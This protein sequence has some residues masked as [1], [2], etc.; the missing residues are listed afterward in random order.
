MKNKSRSKQKKE[1]KEV[2]EES[3][4]VHRIF[5]DGTDIYVF[6]VKTASGKCLEI[7]S[8]VPFNFDIVEK[9]GEF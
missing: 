9:L 2:I 7:Q 8:G 5:P 4:V 3:L 1:E 6:Q